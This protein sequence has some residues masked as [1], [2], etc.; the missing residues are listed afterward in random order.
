MVPGSSSCHCCGVRVV[1][2]STSGSGKSSKGHTCCE[3]RGRGHA[4]PRFALSLAGTLGV[5]RPIDR[6]H[7]RSSVVSPTAAWTMA[8]V[9]LPPLALGRAATG[10]TS[11]RDLRT[12]HL[13][14]NL[15]WSSRLLRQSGG[16]AMP[17]RAICDHGATIRRASPTAREQGDG[18]RMIPRRSSASADRSGG[19]Q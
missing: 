17:C 14:R 6:W 2:A 18:S 19:G 15:R 7:A 13:I 5:T 9:G 8:A 3:I 1:R 10:A 16:R 12:R 11:S 4:A